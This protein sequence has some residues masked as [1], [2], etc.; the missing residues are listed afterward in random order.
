[1]QKQIIPTILVQ[2]FKEVEEKIRLVED[3]V[4]WVQI[5]IMDGV[6]VNNVTWASPED[7]KEFETKAKIEAHLMVDKPEKIIDAWLD[8][9]DR[10][11]VHQEST[12]DIQEVIE[13]THEKGKQIGIALSPK[14]DIEVVRPFLEKLDLILLMSV[15]PGWGGQEFKIETLKKIKSLRNIWPDGNIE[16]DGGINDK[17]IKEI[18]NAGANLF[19]VG[20]Y[21]FKNE[22]IELALK[23]L[24][25][26]L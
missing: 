23:N 8:V 21:I 16:A 14:T 22:N 10:I 1:M 3:C 6:F 12:D 9:V 11:I 4:E 2:T 15:E 20:S 17:N 7:L 5:D 18:S 25:K 26:E 24:K 13:K 19:C